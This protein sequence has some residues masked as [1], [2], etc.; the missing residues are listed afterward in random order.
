MLNDARRVESPAELADQ[1][2]FLKGNCYYLDMTFDQMV[3]FRFLLELENDTT[4][5]E[6][7]FLTEAGIHPGDDI[8]GM[9][10]RNWARIF[11]EKNILLES[12]LLMREKRLN[13]SQNSF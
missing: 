8:S 2:G 12:G 3:F 13:L 9:P 10:G 6:A 7:L 4:P 1:L 5:I 11:L